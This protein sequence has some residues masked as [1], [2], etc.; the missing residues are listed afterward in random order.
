MTPQ[1]VFRCRACGEY[2]VDAETFQ[3]FVPPQK[4][5]EL[6]RK[7]SA[8]ADT[9]ILRFRGKCPRCDDFTGS[10]KADIG[11]GKLRTTP[12]AKGA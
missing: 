9:G 6:Q 2:P 12:P 7:I 4:W 5:A 8:G 11:T 1:Y 10:Y 3:K